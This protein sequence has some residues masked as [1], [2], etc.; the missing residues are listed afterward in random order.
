MVKSLSIVGKTHIYIYIYLLLVVSPRNAAERAGIA[1]LAEGL[2][3]PRSSCVLAKVR[4][5]RQGEKLG[6]K[7]H[8]LRISATKPWILSW[9]THRIEARKHVHFLLNMITCSIK[10]NCMYI[11]IYIYIYIY[12]CDLARKKEGSTLHHA[13]AGY[14]QLFVANVWIS[15]YCWL[16]PQYISWYQHKMVG[17]WHCWDGVYP[18]ICPFLRAHLPT[19][20]DW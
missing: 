17:F 18:H 20:D 16:Y 12:P 19:F 11:Y 13:L 6:L 3:V 5:F 9:E 15:P 10:H 1:Q 8:A 4:I 7:Q 2:Y 14:N